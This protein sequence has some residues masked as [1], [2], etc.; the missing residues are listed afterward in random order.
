LEGCG[1][2]ALQPTRSAFGLAEVAA[3]QGRLTRQSA[4]DGR[5]YLRGK[6]QCRW[7]ERQRRS[8][9]ARTAI[10][11]LGGLNRGRSAATT[12]GYVVLAVESAIALEIPASVK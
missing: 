3:S 4:K 8:L 2:P 7:C 11:R 10:H 6:S 12:S 9:D 5:A 1:P